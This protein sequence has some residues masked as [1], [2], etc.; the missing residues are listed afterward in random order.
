MAVITTG[1]FAYALYPG[2]S[3]WYQ[4]EYD[5]F[6]P[7]YPE[8]FDYNKS[9]R[10]YEEEVGITGFGLAPVKGEGDSISYDT[11]EQGYL[12]RY[13][14]ITYGLGFIITREMVDDDLYDVAA[15]RR[16]QGLAFSMRQTKETVGANVLN[17]AFN[18]NYAG[19]DG[20]EMCSLLHTNKSGGTWQNEPTTPADLSEAALE[21]ACID[22]ADFQ[23]DRGL[24]IRIL[25]KALIIP[26]ELQFEAIRILKSTLQPDTAENNIN[27]LRS[28]GAIPRVAIN[29]YLTDTDAWFIKTNCK[30]GMKW[31]ERR[32]DAFGV[33][34]DFD[35][36]NAKF[37][38]TARYVFGWTDPRGVYGSPGSG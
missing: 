32:K 6:V 8:I 2:I 12:K 19:A 24:K 36:E 25:P 3:K 38:A 4:T 29:H 26:P 15:K 9:N 33:D 21:Q 30:D 35:T 23:T 5:E 17:R 10:A 37:K 27:A 14:H 31:Y 16:A 20:L 13:T 11:Q 34:N 22:I 1:H 7:E 28:M 18:G